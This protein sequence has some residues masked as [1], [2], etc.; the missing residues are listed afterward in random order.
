MAIQDPIDMTEADEALL[1]EREID[2]AYRR[3]YG[4]APQ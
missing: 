4:A 3:G 2:E 1:R